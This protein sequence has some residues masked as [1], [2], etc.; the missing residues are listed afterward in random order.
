MTETDLNHSETT[1]DALGDLLSKARR[2][3]MLDKD[4]EHELALRWRDREDPEAARR[5]VES[6]LRLA[7]KIARSYAGYGLPLEDLVSE[8]LVGL[9][10]AVR[11]FDPDRDVRFSTY[12][13]WWIRAAVQEYVLKHWSQV[14]LGT[15]SSQ[16][17]LFFNLNKLKNKLGKQAG[18]SLLPEDV[19]H[20]A[21][22][23]G[24]SENDVTTMHE[25]LGGR[26]LSLQSPVTEDGGVEWQEQLTDE[27]SSPEETVSSREEFDH[28]HAMLG[29]AMKTLTDRQRR[30][31]EARRLSDD[32]MTL[33]DLAQIYGISR[34]R[35]R[36]IENQAFEKVQKAMLAEARQQQRGTAS[37]RSGKHRVAGNAAGGKSNASSLQLAA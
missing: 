26:D 18:E 22:A 36:Q 34:E 19:S 14:K 7:V 3:P 24:V 28:R 37:R 16:K 20:I 21:T 8:A 9:M 25:R 33:E 4:E 5:L 1:V 35:V 29:E 12:A 32:P 2:V 30:I 6:H 17:K 27:G 23:L 13:L 11:K 10:Q 31:L 15:T